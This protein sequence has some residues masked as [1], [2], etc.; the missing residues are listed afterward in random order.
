MVTGL[1]L[2]QIP[3]FIYSSSSKKFGFK[4]ISATLKNGFTIQIRP[5]IIPVFEGLLKPY[6]PS[7]LKKLGLSLSN[8]FFRFALYFFILIIKS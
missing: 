4:S 5:A 1:I 6:L 2:P 7:I 8:I 3:I